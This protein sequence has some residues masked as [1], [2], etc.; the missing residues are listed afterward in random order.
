MCVMCVLRTVSS[1]WDR[2][3]CQS[4]ENRRIF[5]KSFTFHPKI[6]MCVHVHVQYI[7][8]RCVLIWYF[9]LESSIRLQYSIEVISKL[10]ICV[11]FVR[12]NVCL[13]LKRKF[14]NV[15]R[16][17]NINTQHHYQQ[18]CLKYPNQKRIVTFQKC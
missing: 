13:K 2:V 18:Q 6:D 4:S 12:V 16:D 15:C 11:L 14:L 1:Y 9:K 5:K 10:K 7:H 17:S 8:R 3:E